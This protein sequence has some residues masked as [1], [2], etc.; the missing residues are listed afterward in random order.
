MKIFILKIAAAI[1]LTSCSSVEII[2]VPSKAQYAQNEWDEEKQI[3]A[4]NIKGNR[5]YMPRPFIS[6]YEPFVV[7]SKVFFLN[8]VV[9]ADGKYIVLGKLKGDA[10]K[11]LKGLV[12]SVNANA[13]IPTSY[14]TYRANSIGTP[15]TDEEE[16]TAG[17]LATGV[18]ESDSNTPDDDGEKPDTPSSNEKAAQP[19]TGQSKSIVTN[20]NNAFAVTPMRR[21][22][23]I[24]YLPDFDEQYAVV[25]KNRLGNST[26]N[27]AMGQGWSLQGLDIKVDNNEIN[28]RIF[29]L[30]DFAAKVAKQAGLN[31]LGIPNI[32]T[33]SDTVA[34][35]ISEGLEAL[36]GTQAG[37]DS[38]KAL[39][40]SGQPITLKITLAD[41]ASPGI[42]PI[43]KP[44]EIIDFN[45]SQKAEQFKYL[46]QP[47][48]F[49]TFS[50]AVVEPLATGTG[51]GIPISSKQYFED[52]TD[53]FNFKIDGQT[54]CP[55]ADS[56]KNNIQPFIKQLNTPRDQ[57]GLNPNGPDNQQWVIKE[58]STKG[59]SLI[60]SIDHKDQNLAPTKDPVWVKSRIAKLIKNE[61]WFR[62]FKIITKPLTS[63]ATKKD[64][65]TKADAIV[66]NAEPGALDKKD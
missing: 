25:I 41:Y 19:I 63:L 53:D 8:G 45:P 38:A 42:Y 14:L 52:T 9:T 15:Q 64:G 30:M 20:D 62:N 32:P 65:D 35:P 44:R 7:S 23:D 11:E 49:N 58:Y 37:E 3:K 54:D 56:I 46:T 31:A 39:E 55:S 33:G 48:R 29:D 26:N 36:D 5:Y 47:F 60:F 4:D 50:Y 24:V 18:A 57:D 40:T 2:K 16:L 13:V 43:L 28:K 21:Y 27:L 59:C 61:P 22:F 10:T 6:V 34:V 17:N 12:Q 1:I 51:N 66:D